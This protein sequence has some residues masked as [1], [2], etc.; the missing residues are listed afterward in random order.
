M[1]LAGEELANDAEA[2]QVAQIVANELS[3]NRYDG[4]EVAVLVFNI[5]GQLIHKVGRGPHAAVPASDAQYLTIR[6]TEQGGLGRRFEKAHPALHIA[7]DDTANLV[8]SSKAAFAAAEC[9]RAQ[10]GKRRRRTI[11][12]LS[13]I[14]RSI[15]PCSEICRPST[16]TNGHFRPVRRLA[17]ALSRAVWC[18]YNSTNRQGAISASK[19]PTQ[20]VALG[21]LGD[22]EVLPDHHGG[23][24]REPRGSARGRPRA[25]ARS[26]CG[27]SAS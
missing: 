6:F 23:R 7:D 8:T 4:E 18:N 20:R 21:M 25:C 19:E 3:R 17:C 24:Y 16:S 26:A 27:L 10:T 14:S 1:D 5:K 11:Q 2:R 13:G 9:L 15:N 22:Q 12:A